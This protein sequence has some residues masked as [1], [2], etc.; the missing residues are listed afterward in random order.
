MTVEAVTPNTGSPTTAAPEPPTIVSVNSRGGTSGNMLGKVVFAVVVFGILMIGFLV[1]LNRWRASNHAKE[2]A[3]ALSVK[4]ENKPAQVGVR[5]SFDLDAPP[6]PAS[7]AARTAAAVPTTPCADGTPGTVL[8]APDG[9]PLLAPSGAPMRACRDGRVIVPAIVET[10]GAAAPGAA[11]P[12][13]GVRATQ[14]AQQPAPPPSRYG[15]DVMLASST[16]STSPS[17]SAMPGPATSPMQTLQMMQELL[18]RGGGQTQASAATSSAPA[19]PAQTSSPASP[20]GSIG[21]LLTPSQTP[22]VQAAK[23]GDRSLLLPKGRTVDCSLSTRVVSD[24][25][26]MATCVLTS[27][28]YSDNGRV[29]LLER[30][31]EAVGEYSSNVSQGQRRLFLLWTRVKTP[32]GVVI[33]LNSPAADALGT[34]GLDGYVDNHWWERIGAAFM[35]SIVQD[36]IAYKTAEAS[37]GGGGTAVYQNSAQTTNRFAEKV[38]DSTINIKPTIY[39]NQGDRAT[40]FV[41]RDLDFGTVYALRAR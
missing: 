12:A 28:V 21:T 41:A 4:N 3:A 9:T 8:L 15:G 18:Q 14:T 34:S 38:L 22:M 26:G 40:I 2:A 33:N 36:A 13:I 1:V 25:A 39:K 24:I 17:S 20:P 11:P 23:L 37:A 31:S 7:A 16:G 10:R 29:V 35:L 30:G 19:A 27:N 5:R 32:A 6:L